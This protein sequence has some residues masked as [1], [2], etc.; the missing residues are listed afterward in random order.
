MDLKSLYDILNDTTVQLRNGPEVEERAAPGGGVHVTEIFA[1]PHERDAKPNIEKVNLEFLVIGVDRDAAERR[2][3][4][5]IGILNSYPQPDRLAGGPS[6]IEVGA[7]IGDQGAAFQLFALG[8]VLGVW[9][10]ITPAKMG[11]TGDEAKQMAG[12]GFIM[13]TGYRQTPQAV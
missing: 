7:E 1:M 12:S 11:F 8:K 13:I 5:L 6:Y 9:D 10:V 2:K 3:A 4:E